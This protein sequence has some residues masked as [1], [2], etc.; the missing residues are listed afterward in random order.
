MGDEI[1]S[2]VFVLRQEI[3]LNFISIFKSPLKHQMHPY[4]LTILLLE[5]LRIIVSF[6]ASLHFQW[7][8]PC[9]KNKR[10]RRQQQKT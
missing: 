8:R 9:L 7:V 10:N 4:T 6:K 5:I 1:G 3:G 2:V